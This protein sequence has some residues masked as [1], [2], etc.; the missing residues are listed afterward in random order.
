MRDLGETSTTSLV[1]HEHTKKTGTVHMDDSNE[2]IVEELRDH[3]KTLQ[4][5]YLPRLVEWIRMLSSM[6]DPSEIRKN[7]IQSRLRVLVNLRSRVDKALEKCF[8][9]VVLRK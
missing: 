3:E 7:E 4:K 8:K 2:A 6:N 1:L 5:H 9:I